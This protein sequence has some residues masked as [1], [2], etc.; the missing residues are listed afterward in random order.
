MAPAG[1]A[2]LGSQFQ[3]GPNIDNACSWLLHI[4]HKRRHARAWCQRWE[5]A[6]KERTKQLYHS[7]VPISRASHGW[8]KPLRYKIH[9]PE[10]IQEGGVY[11]MVAYKKRQRQLSKKRNDTHPA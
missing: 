11:N 5:H 6:D 8:T 9:P 1:P 10:V 7:H 4:P 2:V 3:H